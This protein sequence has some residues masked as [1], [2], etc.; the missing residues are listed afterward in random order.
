MQRRS[1]PRWRLVLLAGLLSIWPLAQASSLRPPSSRLRQ[2]IALVLADEGKYLFVANQKSGS[3]SCIDTS[4]GQIST[5]TD[6]G[7][8]LSDLAATPDGRHFLALDETAGQVVLLQRKSDRLT[9]LKRLTVSPTPASIQ[10]T[11]DGNKAI[12]AS[13]WPRQ[14]TILD[15]RFGAGD[16]TPIQKIALPFAPGKLIVLGTSGK[17]LVADAF[18]GKLAVADLGTGSIDSTRS[19]PGHNIRGLALG[20]DGSKLYVTHQFLHPL[21]ASSFDDIHWGNLLTNHVRMILVADLLDPKANLLK[22][23]TLDHLGE[24]SR[25]AGDPAGMAK[26]YTGQNLVA[27]SG[28]HELAIGPGRD[29]TYTRLEVGQR[30]TAVVVAPGG[31]VAYVANTFSDSISVIDVVPW[32][33]TSEIS[34]GSQP[35]LTPAER[36]ER[37]FHD[38]RLA[39]DGW[40]SCQT[41][42][43]EGHTPGLLTDNQT[44]GSF[45]TPKRILS[46]RGVADTGPYAWNGSMPDLEAQ[47]RTSIEKTMQGAKPTP[48]Q[49]TDLAAFLRTLPAPPR[50]AE[51][52]LSSDAVAIRRGQS[53]FEEQGCNKCHTPP[54]FTSAKTYDVGL[55]DQA[56]LRMFNPPSLRGVLHGGPYF[57]DNRVATLEEVF[58][59][60]RHQL[61]EALTA[62]QVEDLT[63]YLRS[64]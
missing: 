3:I 2:P 46:L 36:G 51:L 16:K 18:G 63:S 25:G 33:V 54:A 50:A 48:E 22:N 11:P 7:G 62:A 44:D 6:L 49:V 29:G 42:H 20:S 10:V 17:L 47:V 14:L 4:T 37:L 34:L 12:V 28:V 61:K 15:L 39:H 38:A 35:T 59:K 13:P 27:L 45:G 57:H 40:M 32:R 41:C 56:G 52:G 8:R 21:G 53:I 5:D 60:Q 24:A 58:A 9:A 26:A 31:R 1:W 43:P 19:I 30:P 23:S 64:L 55:R